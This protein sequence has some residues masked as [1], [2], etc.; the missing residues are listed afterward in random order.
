MILNNEVISNFLE[1]SNPKKYVV[2]IET[3]YG[4]NLANLIINDP[5]VGKLLEQVPFKPFL[6]VKQDIGQY[7]YNGDKSKTKVGLRERN[8]TIKTLKTDNNGFTPKRMSDGYKFLVETTGTYSDLLNFFID[9]GVNPKSRDLINPNN[10]SLGKWSDLFM[11]ISP[12]EQFMIQTG[13]RLFKGMDD[14][15]DL[16]R[17]QFDFETT[18]LDG[19]VDR[20]FQIGIRNNRGFEYVIE[21][22]GDNPKE[23]REN[24]RSAIKLMGK[25]IDD[26]KPD[27][28]TGYNSEDFDW[29]FVTDRCD[30]L[31]INIKELFRGL[32]GAPLYRTQSTIKLGGES[33]HYL[34]SYMWGYNILDISHA[35]RKTMAINS[36]IKKWSLKYITIYSKIVKPNR[37]YVPG[38]KIHTTWADTKN[39][40]LFNE[41]NGEW[42]M[43]EPTNHIH[44]EKL[45]HDSFSLVQ[46]DYIVQR[47]LLDDLWETE[48]V[49]GIFNQATFLLSKIIPTSFMRSSTMGTA[50]IWK[51]IMMA[52]SYQN[53]LAIPNG[54]PQQTFTGGLSR[55]L[56]VGYA[57]NVVKLD[58]AALYPNTEITHDI[59]PDIDISGVMKGLLNYIAETRDVYKE[60]KGVH[61]ANAKKL[62]KE[63]E[64]IESSLS[65]NEIKEFKDRIKKEQDLSNMYDK[66]QLPIKILANSFFGSFGAPHIFPWGDIDCAEETTC[67]GRQYLRLLVKHFTYKYGFRPLV[68]DTDGMNFAIPDNIDSIK[69]TPS[70]S[71]RM[72]SE[73]ANQELVGLGAVVAEFNELYMVGRM[74]L[75]IDD[76]CNSTLNFARKNYANDIGGKIKLVGNS[77]KSNKMSGYIEDF[78]NKGIRL[79]LDG[80]GYDFINLYY[81][82]VDQIVNYNIPLSKIASKA[83]IKSTIDNY[84]EKTKQKNKAGNP[85]PRQAH[86]ELILKHDLNVNL[87]DTIYYVNTGSTKSTGDIKTVKLPNGGVEV[88]LGCKLI[89]T[90]EI[91]N[92]PNLTTDEYNAPKYLSAFNTRIKPLLVC[93][94]SEIRD[95]IIVDLVKDRKTK[96]IVL[97]EKSYF[98]E[99]ECELTSGEPFS[100]EDQDDVERN[101]M[102]ME[103][104]EVEFW[105]R[106]DKIPNHIEE[107]YWFDFKEKFIERKKQ[108]HIDG[109]EEDKNNLIKLIKQLRLSDYDLIN[110]A[111]L[112]SVSFDKL[113]KIEP[114]I[115]NNEVIG[116]S[117]YSKK[118]GDKLF[119]FKIFFDYYDECLL[120]EAFY[121]KIGEENYDKW[122]EHLENDRED[123]E[124]G[125]FEPIQETN[126]IE[127]IKPE[128]DEI[129][130]VNHMDVEAELQE[131]EETNNSKD[132]EENE[133][134][135]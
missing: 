68:C 15:D 16:H 51:L 95:K 127:E 109:V 131:K 98:T 7:L 93:F 22:R 122:L 17:L 130:L 56:E 124:S 71:H 44:N 83:K 134:G 69:Y 2:A 126:V 110:S 47:Y 31:S 72:T 135:F 24:E 62:I 52:W 1:G 14:Y 94:S 123:I 33:Q 18:G 114:D 4:S 76:I 60:L 92:N 78:I 105:L 35:V 104:K 132:F 42:C 106:V 88:I 59:F 121:K 46:G 53:D 34:Q 43:Y 11:L 111:I 99:K 87:G 27:V 70:G 117:L 102:T 28:I 97:A 86:M 38:D 29:Q 30:I 48:K 116:L 77:I 118:W 113:V 74:G 67:R 73:F 50:S 90:E 32:N 128:I 84:L 39:K 36:E 91:E 115:V 37:V 64:E 9:A 107:E 108:E 54:Q 26:L 66:K 129:V 112:P 23:I 58:Y 13:I 41:S 65:E 103:D 125:E 133:W 5:N 45:I 12:T 8:V 79:L 21:V 40:Y 100:P 6:W 49:D 20:I 101:L 57:R 82:T 120:K 119:D 25:I 10:P 89:P 75:D 61:G 81:D 85:M 63:L 55:L 80:K 19:K 3:T 96:Q